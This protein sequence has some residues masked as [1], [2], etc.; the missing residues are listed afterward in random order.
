MISEKVP[1]QVK[2]NGRRINPLSPSSDTRKLRSPKTFVE[3][4]PKVQG[5][6]DTTA[7][8][9]LRQMRKKVLQSGK[10]EPPSAS[11]P[12]SLKNSCSFSSK[13]PD[14]NTWC[15]TRMKPMPIARSDAIIALLCCYPLWV[16]C[17]SK[18]FFSG[19]LITSV[20]FPQTTQS[21][22]YCLSKGSK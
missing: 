17:L 14:A 19:R 12:C 21:K 9:C 5:P 8:K 4:L 2:L 22:S 15:K 3:T 1:G 20:K 10:Q 13:T 18:G 11:S 16:S 6:G 7:W